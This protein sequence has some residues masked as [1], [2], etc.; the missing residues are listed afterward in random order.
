[1]YLLSLSLDLHLFLDRKVEVGGFPRAS[2]EPSCEY[3]SHL[4]ESDTDLS[5]QRM[6]AS[7]AKQQYIRSRSSA[8]IESAHRAKTLARAKELQEPHAIFECGGQT[9]IDGQRDELL[10][11]IRG[12]RPAETVFEVGKRGEENEATEALRRQR[13]RISNNKQRLKQTDA[14]Q[15]GEDQGNQPLDHPITTSETPA[16]IPAL[17]HGNQDRN[18]GVEVDH[19]THRNSDQS[20]SPDPDALSTWADGDNFM[21]YRPRETNQVEDKGYSV[22]SGSGH[23]NFVDAARGVI[24][25]LDNDESSR[26]SSRMRW[27][28]RGKKY[29]SQ[30]NDED[31]S[32]GKRMIKGESGQK[33]AAT[34]RSGKFEAWKKANRIGRLARPG[35]KEGPSAAPSMPSNGRRFKHFA[36]RTPKQPDKY[37]DD[38][39]KQKKKLAERATNSGANHTR[40]AKSELRSVED[41]R[42]QRLL[43]QKR[44]EKN[45]RPS[46]RQRR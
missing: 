27:D 11:R 22:H 21:S 29:V 40:P 10:S 5:M 46:K 38:Y 13:T 12:F 35:E 39:H 41:V 18:V 17:A 23:T 34:F 9:T 7:R 4:L 1:M 37:R 19:D 6:V 26:S 30:A 31:G 32:K 2:I 16:S 25:D 14:S 24:M 15:S 8:S 28:K 43:K 42:K 36:E 20:D 44:R 45:A 3:V 33:L